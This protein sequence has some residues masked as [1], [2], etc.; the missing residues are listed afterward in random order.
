MTRR[1]SSR[2]P[3]KTWWAAGLRHDLSGIA[4]ANPSGMCGGSRRRT[5]ESPAS[6]PTMTTG[7][8]VAL[9]EVKI[10]EVRPA[11]IDGVL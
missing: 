8:Q 5:R 3:T 7:L 1:W 9:P 6:K 2:C 10:A 11:D 4:P